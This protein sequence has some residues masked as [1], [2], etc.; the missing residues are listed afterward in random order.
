MK[1]GDEPSLFTILDKAEI[2][3][4]KLSGLIDS[5]LTLTSGKSGNE[6]AQAVN[7]IAWVGQDVA[8]ELGLRLQEALSLCKIEKQPVEVSGRN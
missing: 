2:A 6:M 8:E 5:L 7:A 4:E 1:T 3:K